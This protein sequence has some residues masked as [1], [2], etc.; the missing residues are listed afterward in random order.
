MSDDRTSSDRPG[1]IDL[2]GALDDPSLPPIKSG[3]PGK[4]ERLAA[5]VEFAS[6]TLA[7]RPKLGNGRD[8]T[9]LRV[10]SDEDYA[11][12][13]DEHFLDHSDAGNGNR[14][15]AHNRSRVRFVAGQPL[16]WDGQRW[17]TD[18]LSEVLQL[19]AIT[20]RKI[21][22]EAESEEDRDAQKRV[23]RWALQSQNRSRLD[24]MLY[25][26]ASI[27]GMSVLADD[28]DANPY[29]LNCAN[30]TLDLRTGDLKKPDP[31]DMI[32]RVTPVPYDPDA[33]SERWDSFLKTALPELEAREF[34]QLA[35]GYTAI[36]K[37]GADVMLLIYGP[38]RTGKGTFQHA[39]ASA[40]GE[41]ALT[42]GLEDLSQRR[43]SN[44]IRPEL[45]RLRGTRMASIYETSAN[46]KLSTGWVKTVTGG[47]PITARTL[48]QEPITFLPAFTI[49]L[50]SNHAPKL[51]PDDAA[52][53]ERI[54]RLSFDT[55]IPEKDRDPTLRE[56]LADPKV[57]GPAVLAWIV[58]GCRK[59][60][61]QDRH[62]LTP[63]ETVRRG[64]EQL[65]LGQ[66]H[67]E[68][69][70]EE[71]LAFGRGATITAKG[72]RPLY[73]GWCHEA[74]EEAMSAKA[75]GERLS[76]RGCV[77]KRTRTGRNWHGV[78]ERTSWE[79]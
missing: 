72:L 23:V 30:G 75:V 16:L 50:A 31:E 6:E 53:W 60:L 36:G 48:H 22:S 70:F 78:Q 43:E 69:F 63:P 61:N 41:Y 45:V 25:L 5:E 4:R 9:P 42:A 34:A 2:G 66:D 24:A 71:C 56:E 21:Y 58:D 38:T 52:V 7:S 77:S 65:R 47:D 49:W 74:G 55:V 46:L 68:T 76:D 33:R 73:E 57:G 67:L 10:V 51:P 27:P 37:T 39:L 13:L 64:T 3:R 8:V 17:S 59:F 40:L 26:A 12:I 18:S 29:L 15:A 14:F 79:A 19:A 62:V 11:A 32:T 35:A 44:A 28:L 54:R 1:V 20:A